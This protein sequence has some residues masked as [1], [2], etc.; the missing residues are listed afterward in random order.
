[1]IVVTESHHKEWFPL[2]RNRIMKSCN[3]GRLITNEYKNLTEIGSEL[4]PK[5]F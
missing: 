5:R 4:Q 2:D 3:S 1:M